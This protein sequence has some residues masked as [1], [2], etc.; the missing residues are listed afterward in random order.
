MHGHNQLS[1]MTDKNW[2]QSRLVQ[3][4]RVHQF[5]YDLN[6]GVMFSKQVTASFTYMAACPYLFNMQIPRR[7]IAD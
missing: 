1:G 7:P 2:G 6:M 3:L 4:L 5:Y